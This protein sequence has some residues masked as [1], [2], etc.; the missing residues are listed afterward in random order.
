MANGACKSV[1]AMTEKQEYFGTPLWPL[2]A[3]VVAYTDLREAVSIA[4]CTR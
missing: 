4:A 3:F 1:F 2:V